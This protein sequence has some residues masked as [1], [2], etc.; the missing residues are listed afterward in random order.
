[1]GRFSQGGALLAL[2][3]FLAAPLALQKRYPLPITSLLQKHYTPVILAK[4][5]F[6]LV[7]LPAAA[8]NIIERATT[9]TCVTG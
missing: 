7:V 5:P 9:A 4:I 6:L 2:G 3:F 8:Y 1:V